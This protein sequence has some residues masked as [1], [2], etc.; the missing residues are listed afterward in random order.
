MERRGQGIAHTGFTEMTVASVDAMTSH[1]LE[2]HNI[3]HPADAIITYKVDKRGLHAVQRYMVLYNLRNEGPTSYFELFHKPEQRLHVDIAPGTSIQ[4][5]V[6]H[7]VDLV[8]CTLV[9]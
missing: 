3:D 6:D 4:V 7:A 1:I 9:V 8:K 2:R 5:S